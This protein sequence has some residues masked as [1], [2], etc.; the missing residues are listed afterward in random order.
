LRTSRFFF[1]VSHSSQIGFFARS[2]S[3]W[4]DEPMVTVGQPA[5]MTPPCVVESPMRAAGLLPMSTV[6]SPF[7]TASG[8]P[9][10]MS[11]S[12]SRAAG[13]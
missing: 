9:T 7:L 8:G 12:P 2:V 11:L 6:G 5:T 13:I 1:F 10:Q 3:P 4:A